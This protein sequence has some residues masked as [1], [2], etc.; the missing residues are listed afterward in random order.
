MTCIVQSAVIYEE[1]LPL[2]Y[3]KYPNHYQ[4]IIEFSDSENGLY[5][6][7]NCFKE[8]IENF[9]KHEIDWRR[10]TTD[11]PDI[12]LSKKINYGI[13]TD[14]LNF[15]KKY[16]EGYTFEPNLCHRCNNLTPTVEWCIAMYGGKFKR[17]FGWYIQRKYYEKIFDIKV[18]QRKPELGMILFENNVIENLVRDE[19]GFKHVG[20]M[21]VN[22]TV[23]Y[24]IVKE[25]FPQTDVI[26]H[27]R[28]KELEGLE[29]DIFIKNKRIG[30]EY[31]GKQHYQPIKHFGGEESFKKVKER[32]KK[33]RQLCK[34]L[35]IQ[36]HIIKYN[37]TISKEVVKSKLGLD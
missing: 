3:V 34:K 28:G 5:K 24:K 18:V 19:F 21:W 25:L 10:K 31:N 15:Y 9:M 29:I 2:P 33:K 1:G 22:E 17:S 16:S 12:D 37:E 4:W 35:G 13:G 6:V 32:D 8:P 27:Y 26:H 14:T 20:E 36:L 23:L 7:C 30:I 11:Y